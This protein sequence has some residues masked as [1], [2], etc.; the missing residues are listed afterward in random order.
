MFLGQCF[1][2]RYRFG[3]IGFVKPA[4]A[5]Q[6][7]LLTKK[8]LS[9]RPNH[10]LEAKRHLTGLEKFTEVAKLYNEIFTA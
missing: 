3:H 5:T 8:E 2:I 10:N 9:D 1:K 4:Y 7:N 6:L